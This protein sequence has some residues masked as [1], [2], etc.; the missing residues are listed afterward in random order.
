MMWQQGKLN[1]EQLPSGTNLCALL[2]AIIK[3]QT[4]NVKLKIQTKYKFLNFEF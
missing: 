4:T 3:N 2:I 1:A